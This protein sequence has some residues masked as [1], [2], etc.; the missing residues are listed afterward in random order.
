[1]PSDPFYKMVPIRK[2]F[3]LTADPLT[4]KDQRFAFG[5]NWKNFLSKIDS[6]SIAKSQASLQEMLGQENFNHQTF[7]D[8]GSGSGLF[9]L[10]ARL[11]KASVHSFDYDTNSVQCTELLRQQNP[12]LSKAWVVQQGSVLDDAYMQ[13]LTKFDIVYS[14]GVL[15]HTGQM[16]K[17]LEAAGKKVSPKGKLFIAIYNKHWTS[18]MWWFIK[19]TYVVSPKSLQHIIFLAFYGLIVSK[20]VLSGQKIVDLDRGMQLKY[21]IIDWIGGFPYEYASIEEITHFYEGR[22]FK[23]INIKKCAGWTGCNEFVFEKIS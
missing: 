15:H 6:T 14:W 11:M 9:S 2:G 1:M 8:I 23:A 22:G 20:L 3:V 17:A 16:W 10:A 13:K 5:E 4:S 21:D 19:K 7:L 18:S 12:E